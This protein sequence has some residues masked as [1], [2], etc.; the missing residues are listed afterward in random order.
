VHFSVPLVIYIPVI[1]F[2]IYKSILAGVQPLTLA[3]YFLMGLFL[4]TIA[5]YIL[6]RWVFHYI[7]KS[8]WGLRLHFIFHGVHHD[9]PRDALRLVMP[10][11]ASIPLAFGFYFLFTL[12]FH[13]KA[14]TP[15]SLGSYWAI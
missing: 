6:H 2:F 12:F 4:W 13:N 3:G 11:S 5:E 15:F 14:S 9:Y 7:P 10:P 8:Q 1:G